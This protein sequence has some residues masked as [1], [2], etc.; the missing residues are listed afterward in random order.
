M[1]RISIAPVRPPL[2]RTSPITRDHHYTVILGNH[3][4]VQFTSDRHAKAFAA[5]VERMLN[6][7]LFLVN[8]L[9]SEAYLAYRLAWPLLCDR[10]RITGKRFGEADRVIRGHLRDAETALD[11]TITHTGGENGP[12][13]AWQFVNAGAVA[14]SSIAV[15]LASLYR[16]KSDGVD[17][18]RMDLLRHRADAVV[19]M[20]Q[21]YGRDVDTATGYRAS[22]YV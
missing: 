1:K 11:R 3:A 6:D 22:P 18:A 21:T 5:Q 2:D 20:L 19:A 16:E 8:L 7:Q 15:Q 12:F 13:R 14:V 9:L 17:R 4:A 10:S